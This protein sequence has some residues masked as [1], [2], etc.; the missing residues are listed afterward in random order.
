MTG[1]VTICTDRHLFASEWREALER[2]GLVVRVSSPDELVE[3]SRVSAA[4]VFDAGSRA[5][6]EDELLIALGFARAFGVHAV[7]VLPEGGLFSEIEDVID[8]LCFGMSVSAGE[9]CQRTAAALARRLEP[10]RR[11]R[12]EFLTLSPRPDEILAILGDGRSVLLPRPLSADDDRTEILTIEL[13][14]DAS[15]AAI[16]LAGGPRLIIR[17]SALA[18]ASAASNGASAASIDGVRL[19]AR[20]KE[21]RLEAGLTQAELARRTGI[22]RPNI[23]RVEAGRHTPSLETLSRLASAIGV[24]TT[25]VLNGDH[26]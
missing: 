19:G 22:H 20:L 17:A 4:I 21:L 1:T 10:G 9:G 14:P 2:N 23:A 18:H 7:A 26:D 3:A 11:L 8:D 13:A 15:E 24:S 16:E 5:Y 12:F 25:R 6:D